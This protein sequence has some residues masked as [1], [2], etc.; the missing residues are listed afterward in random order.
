MGSPY[1]LNPQPPS[2]ENPMTIPVPIPPPTGESRRQVIEKAHKLSEAAISAIQAARA[3]QQKKLRKFQVD[4]TVRPDD[5][6]KA[7]KNMEDLVKRHNIEVKRI[8][9]AAKKVLEG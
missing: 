7:Q 5:L 1:S 8:T 6:Q 2:P 3:V 9:D 4:R